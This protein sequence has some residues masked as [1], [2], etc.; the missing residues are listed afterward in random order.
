VVSEKAGPV[1]KP[2]ALSKKRQTLT[3]AKATD[4]KLAALLNKVKAPAAKPKRVRT[5]TVEQLIESVDMSKVDGPSAALK[6]F[7]SMLGMQPNAV[8]APRNASS[9]AV[10][11]TFADARNNPGVYK[12]LK[13]GEY[14]FSTRDIAGINLT[15]AQRQRDANAFQRLMQGTEL[16]VSRQALKDEEAAQ[17]LKAQ[18][19]EDSVVRDYDGRRKVRWRSCSEKDFDVETSDGV[20]ESMHLKVW[21]TSELRVEVKGRRVVGGVLRRKD[22]AKSSKAATQCEPFNGLSERQRSAI[23]G[24][25]GDQR[26]VFEAT[27]KFLDEEEREFASALYLQSWIRRILHDRNPLKFP[28]CRKVTSLLS[29]LARMVQA[30]FSFDFTLGRRVYVLP[31]HEEKEMQML[32]SPEEVPLEPKVSFTARHRFGGASD[33]GGEWLAVARSAALMGAQK[34]QAAAQANAS[35]ALEA[36]EASAADDDGEDEDDAVYDARNVSLLISTLANSGGAF[37]DAKSGFTYDQGY[38]LGAPPEDAEGAATGAEAATAAD[39]Q[40]AVHQKMK[41]DFVLALRTLG[42]LPSPFAKPL[43]MLRTAGWDKQ[44]AEWQLVV[45]ELFGADVVQI[46]QKANGDIFEVWVAV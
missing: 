44:D 14:S 11:R 24:T 15:P 36:L 28:P 17:S 6:C 18:A 12:D 19:L 29:A 13:E 32:F 1:A 7:L 26:P 5:S 27:W 2:A 10:A 34:T 40:A 4:S 25:G 38:A 23:F 41:S 43:A 45:R 42:T 3:T 46:A 30:A 35:E 16:M 31:K 33:A 8:V 37:V 20:T 9:G 22:R 21:T 39:A